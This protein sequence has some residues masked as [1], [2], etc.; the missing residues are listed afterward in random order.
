MLNCLKRQLWEW[1]IIKKSDL[2]NEIRRCYPRENSEILAQ[3]LGLTV[4]NLRRRAARLGIKKIRETITNHITNG[5]KLCP[6][7][8]KMKSLDE[9]NKDKYQPN[10]L[11]Y[12]CRECREKARNKPTKTVQKDSF[13]KDKAL[14]KGS[15]AFGVKKT[16]NPIIWI[17]VNGISVKG[18]K[19][20][21]CGIK[22]PLQAFYKLHKN[23]PDDTEQ[24]K[25][26]CIRCMQER[27]KLNKTNKEL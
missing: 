16:R 2:N 25:N 14:N 23:D 6:N 19:C 1:F 7:C 24:R 12:W 27:R 4:N 9:F 17:T 11:D 22:K 13:N 5:R 20:K 8:S 3:R 21:A 10:D 15:M 18:L 26:V